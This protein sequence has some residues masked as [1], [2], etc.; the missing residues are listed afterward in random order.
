MAVT[1]NKSSANHAGCSLDNDVYDKF[2]DTLQANF[3]RRLASELEKNPNFQL[4]TVGP[5]KLFSIYLKHVTATYRAANTCTACSNFFH[6]YGGMVAVD[7]ITGKQSSLVWDIAES[8]V[9]SD[10]RKAVAAVR[11]HVESSDVVG[12]VVLE[13]EWLGIDRDEFR[14]ISLRADKRLIWD[15]ASNKL[16]AYQRG[17][18]MVENVRTL[19]HN[20]QAWSAD[21]L[22]EAVRLLTAGSPLTSTDKFLGRAKWALDIRERLDSVRGADAKRNLTW[23]AGVTAPAGW[24]ALTNSALG[25]LLAGIKDKRSIHN[26]AA[27]WND[28]VKGDNY[29]R[30]KAAPA[31]A[32]VAAA[33]KA[34]EKLG[35]ASALVRRFARLDDIQERLWEPAEVAKPASK[36]AGIFSSV[37]T[38]DEPK[39]GTATQSRV[40]APPV[41]ITW[42]KFT[43]KH[44][45]E[46]VSIA[47]NVPAIGDFCAFVT[48]V[49]ADAKPILKWDNQAKRNPASLYRY[50]RPQTAASFGLIPG[51]WVPVTAIATHPMHWGRGTE[52]KEAI[53]IL[54]G[55]VD[56]HEDVGLA[57]FPDDMR[58]E[59]HEFRSVIEAYSNTHSLEGHDEA[60]ACGLPVNDNA[61]SVPV[62]LRV[63]DK[64]G[65]YTDYLIDRFD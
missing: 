48:A 40:D 49:H 38:K 15:N 47:V 45:P 42:E 53:L 20:I 1:T 36:P 44:L 51:Q 34:F 37:R 10:L 22:R 7:P 2:V 59:Y 18:E 50:V 56:N 4:L 63:T 3:T 43:R 41:S 8:V 12:V 26:I 24:A 60:S 27:E 19:T 33:E 30:P 16:N 9:P 5:S 61:R 57:L 62:R 64:H 11:A 52:Y 29:L 23:L 14:H 46:A 17:S 21:V 6:R 31:A 54:R 13:S 58:G 32:T 65:A 25:I 28:A 55:C 39:S 35:A